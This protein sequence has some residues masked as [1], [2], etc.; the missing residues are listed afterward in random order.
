M[1]Y[2]N[3]KQLENI[4]IKLDFYKPDEKLILE[5]LEYA[6]NVINF[7]ISN[8]KYYYSNPILKRRYLETKEEIDKRSKIE[9]MIIHM[10]MQ[11]QQENEK[12]IKLMEKINKQ[13]YKPSRKFDYDYYRKDMSK[14]NDTITMQ[15]SIKKETRFEDFLYDIYS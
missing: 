7:L 2:H 15:K 12:K 14:K 10:K 8:K 13:Y 11:K 9:K 1:T 4:K 5:I 3:F 6:E